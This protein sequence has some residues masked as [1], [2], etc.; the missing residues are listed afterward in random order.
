ML[1][2]LADGARTMNPMMDPFLIAADAVA[3]ERIGVD[4]GIARELMGE[5]AIPR[6]CC[7]TASRWTDSTSK[8]PPRLS[9]YSVTTSSL[10]TRAQQSERARN[11]W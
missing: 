11:R 9:P 6:S 4:V 10:R 7:T 2:S 3:R 5:A 1:K 8:T